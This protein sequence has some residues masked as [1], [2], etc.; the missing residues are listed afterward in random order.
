LAATGQ[1]FTDRVRQQ[2]GRRAAIALAGAM[3]ARPALNIQ[4]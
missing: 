2:F 3:L 1:A 4:S